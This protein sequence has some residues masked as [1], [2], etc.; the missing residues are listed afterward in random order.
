[1]GADQDPDPLLER[2]R[3]GDADAINQLFA[4]E[5][6][7][8]RRMIELR[9]DDRLRGR[10]DASDIIQEAQLEVYTRLPQY[11]AAPTMPFWVWLRLEV[12]KH[13][14]L[15]HRRHLG[16]AMRDVRREVPIH[17]EAMPPASADALAEELVAR[18]DSPSEAAVRTE[19]IQ[20]VRQAVASLDEMDREIITLRHFEALSHRET[21]EVLGISE[22]NAAKRYIRALD[23][24]QT[25]LAELPGGI[26]G[27]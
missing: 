16:T 15:V 2:A 27:L 1:M 5:R 10:L 18:Q 6:A 26:E 13:L 9:L 4:Q 8:L 19:R 7:R 22:S 3:R 17:G 14:L 11:L 20:R 24:L 21:A 12:G 25:A 23:R